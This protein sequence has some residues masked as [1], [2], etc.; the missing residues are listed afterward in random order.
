MLLGEAGG[1]NEIKGVE[2]AI[3]AELDS[4]KR[5]FKVW[6]NFKQKSDVNSSYTVRHL[7]HCDFNTPK[8]FLA[9]VASR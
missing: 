6:L 8:D 9:Y 2:G 5:Q 7:R 1:A 3:M 4:V